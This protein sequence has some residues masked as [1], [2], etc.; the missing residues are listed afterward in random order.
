MSNPGMHSHAGAMG[1]SYVSLLVV[2]KIIIEA[3]TAKAKSGN[4]MKVKV[5]IEIVVTIKWFIVSS[6][7][8]YKNIEWSINIGVIIFNIA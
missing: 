5:N 1:T 6:L 8:V 4:V 2:K 3:I 7:N